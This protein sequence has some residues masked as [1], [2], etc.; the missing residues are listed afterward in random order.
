[1]NIDYKEK[2]S[3]KISFI[4][5]SLMDSSPQELLYASAKDIRFDFLQ[6]VE[7][8]SFSFQILSLQIDNQLRGTP[9]PVVLSFDEDFKGS[10]VS[11]MRNK[12]GGAKTKIESMMTYAVGI[13]SE[14]KLYLAASKWRNKEMMLLSFEYISLRIGDLSLELDLELLLKLLEF[15]KAIPLLNSDNPASV[16]LNDDLCKLGVVD[17]SF[18][19]A[20][21]NSEYLQTNGDHQFPK[22]LYTLSDNHTNTPLLPEV[23]PIG[24]P[25][26]KIFLLARRQDKIYVEAFS[27]APVK[28]T[29]S[30][31]S[32][33]W[34]LKS[35]G[36]SSGE[37]LIHS[38]AAHVMI[39]LISKHKPAIEVQYSSYMAYDPVRGIMALADVEGAQV[40][41]KELTITH[42]MAS[43]GS[44]QEILLKHYSRQFLHE[45]Y[46]VFG[47]AGV[48]GNPMGF[49]RRVG[50]GVKDFFS[51]PAKGALQSPSGLISGMAQGTSSLLSN[52]L[53]AMSDTATQFSKAAHKGIVAFTFDNHD[54]SK[55]EQQRVV[56]TSRSKGVINELFEGLT[57][58]LQSPIKGAE[59]HGLP[60]VLSG[61]ALGVTG[62]V[63]KPAA[64]VLEA[65]GRT[66]QSIRNRSR[67]YRTGPH[68]LRVRLPRALSA[69]LPL[70]CYSWDEAIG[71]AVLLEVDGSKF[72]DEV[73]VMCKALQ[74]AGEFVV[75]TEKLIL[76]IECSCLVDLGKAVFQGIVAEPEWKLVA[77][78]ALESVIHHKVDGKVMHIVGSSS[79]A[80]I[81]KNQHHHHRWTG[82]RMKLWSKSPNPLPL[83]QTDLEFASKEE[84]EYFLEVLSSTIKKGREQGWGKMYLL[85]QSN[86]RR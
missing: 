63:A 69:E 17:R 50:L 16:T 78:I 41:L 55:L 38:Q 9:Y 77:E 30:F 81:G 40:C 29:L 15:I 47:S 71:T 10:L 21:Q 26:Q 54:A 57:G 1:M 58:L 6:S 53:Y 5:I 35:A 76:I 32:N 62:L 85:H 51:V 44:I 64:S 39:Y 52:T 46:K 37:S 43:W 20:P 22:N 33:P 24:A 66:A 48:I 23:V 45:M 59:K 49:A 25:W 13:S 80:L 86:L 84:A 61:F 12:D 14:P 56:T 68:H 72:R 7:R 60:G 74:V 34:M 73:L 2:V 31:S 67:L 42:H 75:L 8:Q 36:L 27:L 19:F 79:E 82:G 18:S 65:T 3:V 28:M 11:Q 83:F 70:G 4:G